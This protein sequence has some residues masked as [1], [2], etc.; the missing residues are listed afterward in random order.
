MY[1]TNIFPRNKL[2]QQPQTSLVNMAKAHDHAAA[3]QFD[4][5][6]N[7][8]KPQL[9]ASGVPEIYWKT[10][11]HKLENQVNWFLS[12]SILIFNQTLKSLNYRMPSRNKKA[13]LNPQRHKARLHAACCNRC[14]GSGPVQTDLH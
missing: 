10:L 9:E 4:Q 1:F 14:S 13:S 12:M 5:F 2:F 6:F 11:H 3:D 7:L 8:H